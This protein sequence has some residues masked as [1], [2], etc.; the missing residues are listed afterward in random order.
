M[1]TKDKKSIIITLNRLGN[2][3][4]ACGKLSEGRDRECQKYVYAKMSPWKARSKD[5]RGSVHEAASCRKFASVSIMKS[6]A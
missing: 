4:V 6:R 5:S 2:I 1:L 3:H